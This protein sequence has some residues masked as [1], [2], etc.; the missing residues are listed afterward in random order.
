MIQ[1]IPWLNDFTILDSTLIEHAPILFLP[2]LGVNE[3]AIIFDSPT[4]D[5][6]RT[7]S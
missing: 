6:M 7:S 1:E 5:Q 4:V 2:P 3:S